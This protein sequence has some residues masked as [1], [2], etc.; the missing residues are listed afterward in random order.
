MVGA[1]AR[2]WFCFICCWPRSS[3]P[4]PPGRRRIVRRLLGMSCGEDCRRVVEQS[5][6]GQRLF[7]LC[8]QSQ[9]RTSRGATL[10]ISQLRSGWCNSTK[11]FTSRRDDGNARQSRRPFRTDFLFSANQTLRVWLISGCPCGTTRAGQTPAVS[12]ASTRV[13]NPKGFFGWD[14]LS[15][16][17]HP[18]EVGGLQERTCVEKD[19]GCP[20]NTR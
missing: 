1:S 18:A 12:T 14:F 11:R 2:R 19:S 15:T 17:G 10:E 13:G 9:V 20:P 7:P 8:H 3:R 4:S 5:E 16:D 6:D